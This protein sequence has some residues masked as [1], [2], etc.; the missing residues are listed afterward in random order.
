M[1]R[2]AGEGIGALIQYGH[3]I[4]NVIKL[5]LGPGPR[6]LL[7]WV[8]DL[9]AFKDSVL[10]AGHAAQYGGGTFPTFAEQAAAARIET[11]HFATT[12]DIASV[13]AEKMGAE[14]DK[15]AGKAIADR[16]GLVGYRQAVTALTQSL[17]ENGH[18]HGFATEKGAANEQALD[19]VAV[20][21]QKAATAMK[22]DGRSAQDVAHFLDGARQ[23]IIA[24]AEKMHYSAA[25]A[26]DLANKLLGVRD[27]ANSVPSGK[28][29]HLSSNATAAAQAIRDYQRWINALHGK[30]VYVHTVY[31]ASGS[32]TFGAGNRKLGNKD[33]G[34]IHRAMGGP[35]QHFDSGGPSGPVV[36]PGTGTSDS[37]PA[38]LSNGEYVINAKQTEKYR[39]LLDAINYGINGFADGG[40]VQ[41]LAK[42]GKPKPP[43]KAQKAAAAHRIALAKAR[44][45]Y[46]AALA[47]QQALTAMRTNSLMGMAGAGLG[48]GVGSGNSTIVQHVT[49]VTLHVAGSIRS[50]KDIVAMIQ[51]EF[52][53]GRLATALP[54]GR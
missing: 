28:N 22:S 26:R 35:V 25:A 11:Q 23:R 52:L 4:D 40:E 7:G 6:A 15:L 48:A 51:S 12:M 3:A 18:A 8:R 38:M 27:A 29:T 16:E 45:E 47:A 32:T 17:K 46:L 44:P 24:A 43:T 31:T 13:A 19:A 37:I 30:T 10:G 49:N 5:T 9:G 41:H 34:Y 54:A 50:D 42:G 53:R 14:F 2:Y 36:G 1:S 20:A 39:P 33:G 21:A